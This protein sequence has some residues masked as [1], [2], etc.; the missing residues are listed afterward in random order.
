MP[1]KYFPLRNGHVEFN[2]LD[3]TVS[4]IVKLNLKV[5]IFFF[6]VWKVHKL[7]EALTTLRVECHH[8]IKL[9]KRDIQGSQSLNII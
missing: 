7:S 2:L 3:W 8:G 5:Y 9:R 1:P 6:I 4:T